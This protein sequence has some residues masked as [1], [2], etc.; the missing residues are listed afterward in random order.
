MNIVLNMEQLCPECGGEQVRV[1]TCAPAADLYYCRECRHVWLPLPGKMTREGM[2]HWLT[3]GAQSFDEK[4][5]AMLDSPHHIMEVKENG[6]RIVPFFGPE[7]GQLF[8]RTLSEKDGLPIEKTEWA[9]HLTR[10]VPSC[11]TCIFDGEITVEGKNANHT[12]VASRF[13][14][15]L[16]KSLARQQKDGPVLLTVWDVMMVDGTDLRDNPLRERLKVRK[17]LVPSL[18]RGKLGAAKSYVKEVVSKAPQESGLAF[19]RRLMAEGKEGAILKRLDGH[20]FA[21]K[22]PAG[23]WVKIKEKDEVDLFVTGYEAAKETSKKSD[24]TV[25]VTKY[26]GMIGSLKLSAHDTDTRKPVFVTDCSGITDALRQQVSA[27]PKAFLGK[28]LRVKCQRV[29]VNQSGVISLQNP[30][31]GGWRSDKTAV[32]CD[33]A[34][35][36]QRAK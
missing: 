32:Q 17:V 1:E 20:Y 16:E 5:M 23:V 12:Q 8:T 4:Y 31:F 9:P 30:Q 22:R 15:S 10:L 2:L 24:G 13:N 11:E 28:V 27:N 6:E 19:A 33:Y 26:K 14:C 29:T 35:L 21:D 3:M 36:V 34:A 18:N 7:G 25:S